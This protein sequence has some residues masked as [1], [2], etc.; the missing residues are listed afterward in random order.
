MMNGGKRTV[1]LNEDV[2]V[3]VIVLSFGPGPQYE[4][5]LLSVLEQQYPSID[6]IIS[7]DGSDSFDKRKVEAFVRSHM[8]GNIKRL[9]VRQ[10][11][12]NLGIPAHDNLT[13]SL[14]LGRFIKFI[15]DGDTLYNSFSLQRLYHFAA[16]HREWIVTSPCVICS[17]DLKEYYYQF[18]SNRR[19]QILNDR[20]IDHLYRT[21][22]FSNLISAVGCMFRKE[23]FLFGGFDE[24]YHYLEDWPTWLRIVRRGERIPCADEPSEK[25]ALSGVSSS[26]GTA[27]DSPRL[28]EDLIR[29]YEQE[30][31][32]YGNLLSAFTR[33]SAQ[34]RYAKL[35][36]K[37]SIAEMIK[38]LPMVGYYTAKSTVKKFMIR[39]KGGR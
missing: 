19:V 27:F 34:Y 3:T 5:T 15:A 28:R 38:F 32:P 23:F 22:V 6:L 16:E 21:L 12:H 36:G 2:L 13:A 29:C 8:R 24:S 18:P 30:I 26:Y 25:Y 4:K 20:S 35:H 10:N 39:C 17:V 37:L 31:L 11:E 7:D 33:Y 1:P 9:I 14:A